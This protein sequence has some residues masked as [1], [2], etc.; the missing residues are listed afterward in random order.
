VA[1]RIVIA[2]SVYALLRSSLDPP[3]IRADQPLG[4]TIYNPHLR[5]IENPDLV[6]NSSRFKVA[7]SSGW[8]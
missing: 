3:P 1:S 7:G 4:G 2:S 8:V 6:V 5:A